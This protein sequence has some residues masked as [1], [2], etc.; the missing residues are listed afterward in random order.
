MTKRQQLMNTLTEFYQRPV[1]QASLELFL[2]ICAVLFFAIFA[3]RP[4]LLTMSDL[5]KEIEDKRELS[6]KLD[7]KVA[8]L[9]SAQNELLSVQDRLQVVDQALPSEPKLLESLSY[10]E[11]IASDQQLVIENLTVATLPEESGRNRSARTGRKNYTIN[12]TV[13][14]DYPTIKRYLDQVLNVRR[15]FVIET[16]AFTTSD[17]RGKKSLKANV[18]LGVPY[19]EE[20]P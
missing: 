13:Q 14:G 19:L 20:Q 16:V 15:A 8:A 12:F 2:S 11:K 9:A 10:L 18:T 5:I 17:N 1:A 4:T 6:Q 7:Q 3:I